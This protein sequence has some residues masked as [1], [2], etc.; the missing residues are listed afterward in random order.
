MT[1]VAVNFTQPKHQIFFKKTYKSTSEDILHKSKAMKVGRRKKVEDGEG[2]GRERKGK[3]TK[4][5][6][7]EIIPWNYRK[8]ET[9]LGW[10]MVG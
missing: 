10:W 5:I 8:V 4:A 2:K 6:H 3:P 9:C 7:F 1:V